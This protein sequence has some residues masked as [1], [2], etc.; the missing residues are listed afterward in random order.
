MRNSLLRAAAYFIFLFALSSYIFAHDPIDVV[1]PAV[2]K[3]LLTLNYAIEGARRNV[4]NVRR[5]VVVSKTPLTDRAEWFDESQFPFSK[6][7]VCRSI[8]RVDTHSRAGWYYQQLLKLYAPLVIPGLS[9]NV[10]VHDADVIFLKPVQFLN[11]KQG[12]LYNPGIEKTPPYFKHAHRLVPGFA[13]YSPKFSGIAHHML[14]QRPVIEH[15]FSLVEKSH[16]VPFW[17]AFCNC[18]DPKD[19]SGASEYE[20]YFN[21]AF[22]H[23]DQVQIRPLKWNNVNTLDFPSFTRAG[24]DYIACHSWSR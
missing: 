1:I 9:S 16:K 15:L 8:F 22:Q 6:Q 3:D 17:Q 4:V 11:G 23:T 21:F 13:K 20:I 14:F 7:D 12:G 2:E 24:Y 5:I 19:F 10:L 18:I